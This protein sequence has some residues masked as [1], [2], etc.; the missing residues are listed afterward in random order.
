MEGRLSYNQV[1][2]WLIVAGILGVAAF[3]RYYNLAEN[4]VFT[5]D[6]EHQ[7][8]LAMTIVRDFHPIWIGVNAGH[9][10]FYLGPYWTY[11]TAGWLWLSGGEPL[12]TAYVAA[13]I[14]VITTG[15][16]VYAGWSLFN[17][18]VGIVAGLLYSTL[19]LL[20]YFGQKY[21]NPSLT[22]LLTIVLLISFSK[23]T[24]NNWWLVVAAVCIGAIF[25]TH[26]SLIP[27]ILIG[28]YVLIRGKIKDK[29]AIGVSLL[30][31]ILMLLPLIIFDYNHNWSNILTPFRF[32]EISE[33]ATN[34]IDPLYHGKALLNSL[35]RI[36]FLDPNGDNGDEVLFGCGTVWKKGL[37]PRV[38]VVS[39]Q[40]R[41]NPLVILGSV[42]L[43]GGFLV[44]KKTWQ[45]RNSQ[46]VALFIL[47]IGGFF[48]VFPGGSYEYYLFGL[49]PMILL[50]PGIL[51]DYYPKLRSVI[52]AL[53]III[54]V[55]GINT[56]LTNNPQFGYSA[57][58][59]LVGK[60]VSQI[61]D[62]SI[63]VKQQGLCHYYEG[64]RYLFL[65]AGNRPIK[66]DSDQGLGWLYSNEI[67]ETPSQVIVVMDEGRAGNQ[68]VGQKV[69]MKGF[70]G[71]W[72]E[73]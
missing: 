20:V 68:G 18:R 49:F 10:G 61:G 22:P 55:L 25:H 37:D 46:L 28:G 60:I 38:D 17:S 26:L 51:M 42:I 54:G 24:K 7:V 71:Y 30:A 53:V 31:L 34:K 72:Y 29:K 9:L 5:G 8:T 21:W 2:K 19:P 69:N 73:R 6:E 45:S 57:K 52:W 67:R 56:V 15:A 32:G 41:A 62:K 27:L 48:L 63:E 44:N 64:W 3:L 59:K 50:I 70:S 14:G 33:D 36:W 58:K 11:F 23:L 35:G 4:F 13:V 39:Q 47:A 66:A 43:I 1:M 40:T 65:N 12:I 16:I